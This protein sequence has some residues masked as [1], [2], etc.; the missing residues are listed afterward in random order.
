MIYLASPYSNTDRKEEDKRFYEVLQ[1]TG[2]LLEKGMVVFSPILYCHPV[3]TNF[4]MGRDYTFWSFLNTEFIKLSRAFLVL[5]LEGWDRS[6]G[7]SSETVYASTF[8]LPVRY[9]NLEELR[10]QDDW[11]FTKARRE[12]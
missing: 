7:V 12:P 3:A 11:T 8:G 9:V 6:R 4:K 2:I 10:G 1:A 5:Q